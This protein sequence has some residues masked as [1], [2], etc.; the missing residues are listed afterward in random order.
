[1]SRVPVLTKDELKNYLKKIVGQI[2]ESR[3]PGSFLTM[4]DFIDEFIS[5]LQRDSH[6]LREIIINITHSPD[7][8]HN[9]NKKSLDVDSLG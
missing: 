3:E 9:R 5:M 7:A 8:R 4:G 2:N 1:M 6:F